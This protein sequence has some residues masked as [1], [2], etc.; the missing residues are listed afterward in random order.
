MVP[1]MLRIRKKKYCAKKN[2]R[3]AAEHID[4][5]LS[6]GEKEK[7]LDNGPQF[8]PTYCITRMLTSPE[9]ALAAQLGWCHMSYHHD[10]DP[11]ITLLASAKG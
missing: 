10:N 2:R 9:Q 3:W 7:S 1:M 11:N 8:I 5:S 4:L 6:E